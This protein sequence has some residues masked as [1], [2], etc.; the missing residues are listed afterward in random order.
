MKIEI[1][2]LTP[3]SFDLAVGTLQGA[4]VAERRGWALAIDGH[5]QWVAPA[6]YDWQEALARALRWMEKDPRNG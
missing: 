2:S 6:R 5:R 4:L 3:Q 1:T